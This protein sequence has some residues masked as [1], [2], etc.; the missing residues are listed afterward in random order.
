MKVVEEEGGNL[1][2]LGII[3]LHSLETLKFLFLPPGSVEVLTSGGS[4][5]KARM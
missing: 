1:N 2:N 3:I 5:Y 4:A